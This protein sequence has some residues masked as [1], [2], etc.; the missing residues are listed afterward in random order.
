MKI[1]I[2]GTACEL[3]EVLE[4]VRKQVKTVAEEDLCKE[5]V[6]KKHLEY[7]KLGGLCKKKPQKSGEIKQEKHTTT[8]QRNVE[9]AELLEKACYDFIAM[10]EEKKENKR[11][12]K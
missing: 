7:K 6:Y 2:E 11:E 5:M 4:I 10:Q 12:S 3:A 9:K 8:K 1:T